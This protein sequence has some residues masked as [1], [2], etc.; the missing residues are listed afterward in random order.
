[1]DHLGNRP[2]E[3]A[4]RRSDKT[5]QISNSDPGC[6]T[7]EHTP[8]TP[9]SALSNAWMQRRTT[10]EERPERGSTPSFRRIDDGLL[11]I[12]RPCG[13]ADAQIHDH[14]SSRLFHK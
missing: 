7:G 6:H 13:I 11:D 1:M 2:K 5:R 4:T 9:D 3:G 8:A 14:P 12:E 10:Q